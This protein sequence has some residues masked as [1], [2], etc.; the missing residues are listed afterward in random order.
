MHLGVT[1]EARVVKDG[2]YVIK[3][4]EYASIGACWVAVYV[5]NDKV[6]YF[7]GFGVAHILKEIKKCSGNKISNIIKHIFDRHI[8]L[9]WIY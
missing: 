1:A 3:L 9:Y 5:E 7:D 2:E 4:D 8:L 6:T